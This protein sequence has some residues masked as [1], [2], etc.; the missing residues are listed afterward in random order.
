MLEVAC[1]VWRRIPKTLR[2][3]TGMEVD[4]NTRG[5]KASRLGMGGRDWQRRPGAKGKQFRS[6]RCW[7]VH[8]DPPKPGEKKMSCPETARS[9][10]LETYGW[11]HCAGS[12]LNPD[13]A[14]CPRSKKRL[15][16]RWN[17]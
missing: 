6:G 10:P 16:R 3:T 13:L 15:G 7:S 4:A 12:C 11:L 14:P 17:L 1:D 9:G 5:F 2:L 8:N